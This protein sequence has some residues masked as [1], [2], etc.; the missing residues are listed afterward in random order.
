MIAGDYA[1]YP[2]A[3]IT[4]KP[5]AFGDDRER[6]F[7]NT[8]AS[9]SYPNF[10]GLL[11]IKSFCVCAYLKPESKRDITKGGCNVRSKSP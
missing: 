10:R 1:T 7:G 3:V 8:I 5:A 2:L 4:K 9:H 6:K 11:R